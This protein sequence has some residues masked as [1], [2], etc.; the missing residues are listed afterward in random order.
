MNDDE[1]KRLFDDTKRHFDVV[2]ERVQHEVRLVAESVAFVHEELQRT[3]T[4]LD[5]KIERTAGERRR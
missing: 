4:T 5:E 1:F 2:A 3:R